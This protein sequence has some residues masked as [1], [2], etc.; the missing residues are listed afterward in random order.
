M[1]TTVAAGGRAGLEEDLLL[2]VDGVGEDA[3]RV[4]VAAPDDAVGLVQGAGIVVDVEVVRL[5]VDLGDLDGV[6]RQRLVPAVFGIALHHHLEEAL[7]LPPLDEGAAVLL[8]PT[9]LGLGVAGDLPPEGV[10]V[11]WSI[12]E[13]WAGQR[14]KGRGCQDRGGG[15]DGRRGT[16][17]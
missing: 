2:V 11:G 16:T 10:G 13:G 6:S 14:R 9:S 5:A 12:A 4:G 1:Q 15:G 8:R 3:V 17:S 7:L